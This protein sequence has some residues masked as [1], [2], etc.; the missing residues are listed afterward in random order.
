MASHV[1]HRPT[2]LGVTGGI[3]MGKSTCAKQLLA[4]GVECHD[5][6]ATVHRLYADLGAAVAPVSAAF[7]AAVLAD[8]GRGI[9]RARLMAALT[10]SGDIDAAFLRLEAIVHPLVTADRA[11]WLAGQAARGAWLAAVDV[12]LLFETL[13][14]DH[15]FDH[16]LAVTCNSPDE[17][18]RRAL[19]RPGMT[20]EKLDAI[21]ARQL[22]DTD[23]VGRADFVVDT[24]FVDV[25]AAR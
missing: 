21:L 25:S 10:N 22:D 4:C 7:G 8:G 16:V 17:Q 9:D 3:A 5:S 23:R 20:A 14:D 15:D 13:G 18:R 2:V 24:S 12:P 11:D 6:D 1:A 19:K